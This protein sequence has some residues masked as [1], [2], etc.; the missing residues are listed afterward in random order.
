MTGQRIL[1]R[2]LVAPSK[3]TDKSVDEIMKLVKDHL[4]PQPSSIVQRFKF[5]SRSQQDTETVSQFVAELKKLS[6]HCEFG[7]SLDNMLR[8]RLVC[9]LR[10]VKVQRRLLA[11]GKLTFAKAF[12]LAQ[13]AELTDKNVADLQ[14]PHPEAVHAVKRSGSPPQNL[15]YRCRGRHKASDC[16]FKGVECFCCGEK[17]HLARACR[18]KVSTGSRLPRRGE[19]AHQLQSS[20]PVQ[21]EDVQGPKQTYNL[22]KLGA[23]EPLT[24]VVRV[25]DATLEMEVDTGAAASVI[26]VKYKDRKARLD[27]LVVAGDGPS[28]MGRDWLDDNLQSLLRK[29]AELFKEEL[30]L[31]KGLTVKLQRL[32][33]VGDAVFVKNFSGSPKWIPGRVIANRG[34]L[35]LVI[36][37]DNGSKVNRHV[38]HVRVREQEGDNAGEE[39]EADGDILP[40]PESAEP[41]PEVPADR[42]ELP[43]QAP[44]G[45]GPLYIAC[46]NGHF[47]IVKALVG[48]GAN[49]N[50]TSKMN[51]TPLYVACEKG[52][53]DVV[54]TLLEGGADVEIA[55][56]NDGWSPLHVASFKG[57]LEVVKTLIEAEAN[58]N[59]A[60]MG[61]RL[62]PRRP[63]MAAC[64]SQKLA[65]TYVLVTLVWSTVQLC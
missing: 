33:S 30:G 52:H 46:S 25:D 64:I 1:I 61:L 65:T 22:F 53:L 37:L 10:D 51:A 21:E 40:P 34:P 12:E 19:A 8:D 57:H 7:D 36:Q 29:Y 50:Q 55:M 5:N 16:K 39:E 15:C 41:D 54:Q 58:V 4:T 3:P 28:L 43:P 45:Q 32:F 27:L 13:V 14:R 31:V 44:D 63:S 20:D 9:G 38:D 6:E 59:L 47:D 24:V 49:V 26:K 2:S 62:R 60:T 18:K 42:Q 11:E 23:R 48:A 35:S 56:S 17:G